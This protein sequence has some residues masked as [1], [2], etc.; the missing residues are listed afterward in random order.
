MENC[1]MENG[2]MEKLRNSKEDVH[3]GLGQGLL[4]LVF[5]RIASL[6]GG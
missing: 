2:E 6:S 4:L 1:E 3:A 5:T